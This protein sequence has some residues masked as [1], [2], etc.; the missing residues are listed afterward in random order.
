MLPLFPSQLSSFKLRIVVISFTRLL[1]ICRA[2]LY[3]TSSLTL[4]PSV[5]S[6]LR[7]Q[8]GLHL[9]VIFIYSSFTF[10]GQM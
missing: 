5:F 7:L 10:A 3:L 2:S 9:K 4:Y 1:F 8:H 6:R